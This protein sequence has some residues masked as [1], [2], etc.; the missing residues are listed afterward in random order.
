MT[1]RERGQLNRLIWAQKLLAMATSEQL[2]K[3]ADP[4]PP[5]GLDEAI[6]RG[7]QAPDAAQMIR[8]LDAMLP[9][10]KPQDDGK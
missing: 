5:A 1:R 6:G 2:A 8:A 7:P 3:L 9:P 4:T 10:R